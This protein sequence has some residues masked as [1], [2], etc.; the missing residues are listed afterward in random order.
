[1]ATVRVETDINVPAQRVWDAVRARVERGII[2]IK[3]ILEAAET[4]RWSRR[5]HP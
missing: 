2:E 5:D 1:M 3:Q 4:D